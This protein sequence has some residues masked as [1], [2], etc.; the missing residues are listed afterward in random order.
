MIDNK[1]TMRTD[2]YQT[3]VVEVM[4]ISTEQ[5]FLVASTGNAPEAYKFDE[6][7]TDW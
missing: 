1:T 2:A 4:S 3:P 5:P 6:V 7:L